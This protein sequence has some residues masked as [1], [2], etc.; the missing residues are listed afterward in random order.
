MELRHPQLQLFPSAS[1]PTKSPQRE[2]PEIEQTRAIVKFRAE[3][4]LNTYLAP[5]PFL[6]N[7]SL[8]AAGA[9]L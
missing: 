4:R 5:Q 6:G 1:A 7:E 9:L 3:A 2:L 8:P